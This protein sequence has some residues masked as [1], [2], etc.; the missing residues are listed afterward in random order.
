[1]QR[2]EIQDARFHDLRRTFGYNL[3][4]RGLPIYQVSKILWHAS[5]IT[6]DKHYA[7]LLATDVE[8]FVL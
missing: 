1:M 8:E 3:I 7:P 6:T 2:L 5:V 4:K